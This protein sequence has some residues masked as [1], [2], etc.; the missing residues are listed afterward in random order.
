MDGPWLRQGKAG[1]GGD[2]FSG[3]VP[4]A[5]LTRVGKA[6]NLPVRAAGRTAGA[7]GGGGSRVRDPAPM[8]SR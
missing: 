3:V 5:V 7:G 1:Q 2:F 8:D 4:V 6:M